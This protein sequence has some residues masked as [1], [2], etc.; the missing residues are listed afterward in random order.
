MYVAFVSTFWSTVITWSYFSGE[1][2]LARHAYRKIIGTFFVEP[3]YTYYGIIYLLRFTEN[4]WTMNMFLGLKFC[5][6]NQPVRTPCL[7]A[8]DMFT[9]NL[10]TSNFSEFLTGCYVNSCFLFRTFML[11]VFTFFV[12]VYNTKLLFCQPSDVHICTLYRIRRFLSSAAA[13][14]F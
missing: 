3:C 7:C 14:A 1:H 8:S 6:S 9:V 10:P 2:V 4:L 12:K 5:D 13:V 11:I